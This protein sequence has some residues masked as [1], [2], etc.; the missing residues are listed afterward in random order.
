[1]IEVDLSH[2][3]VACRSE[4]PTARLAA[5]ELREALAPVAGEAGAGADVAVELEHGDDPDGEGFRLA[6]APGRVRLEGQ[7]PRGL[8]YAAY[9]L[10]E[11]L[12]ARWTWPGPDG[13]RAPAGPRLALPAG[14]VAERPALPGR[15][16]VL[17]HRDVLEQVDDWI[18]WAA[19]NRLNTLFVHVSTQR[20]PAAAAPE[21]LW[22]VRRERA[23]ALARE[24][25]MTIEHGG[26]L[27]PELVGPDV[28]RRAG[29]DPGA[30]PALLR[31]ALEPFL[32]AH[33]EA[34]VVH[35]WG[36]DLADGAAAAPSDG[37]TASERALV[38]AN[39]VGALLAE[40]APSAQAAYLAYHDTAPVPERVAPRPNV[41]LLWA[42]RERCYEHAA[43]DPDCP[44]NVRHRDQFRAQLA[45]FRAAGAAPPRVFEYYLDAILFRDGVP[46]L[47]R[48][49]AGDLAFYAAAGA[50]TVQALMTGRGAWARPHPNPWLFARLTWDPAA[51]P[52]ALYDEFRRLTA[53]GPR[54][55]P[56]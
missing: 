35:L 11:A 46:L 19:R 40:V 1:M 5:R 34:A 17:G 25:G 2:W 9:A 31:P 18:V 13:T 54:G 41:C 15:C 23:V 44:R 3:H 14:G 28:L 33:P 22:R 37:P 52:D 16:L 38:G 49:M 7:G 47:G 45:H 6:A 24:R 27:L 4:H 32:R 36:A 42:P 12:G 53:A 39:A 8:L 10:L 48:V 30:A 29:E 50:H 20:A 26:H 43:D 55:G 51:D 56:P 21:D